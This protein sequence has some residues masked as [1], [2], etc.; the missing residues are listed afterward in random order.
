MEKFTTIAMSIL[1]FY[2]NDDIILERLDLHFNHINNE[3][4]AYASYSNGVEYTIKA[5]SS[6][7]INSYT[8]R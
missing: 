1:N 4:I 3:Y 7:Y 2:D 6:F 8:K 5:D